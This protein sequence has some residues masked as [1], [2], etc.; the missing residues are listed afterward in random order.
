MS[1]TNSDI[2]ADQVRNVNAPEEIKEAFS[3]W[4]STVQ[5]RLKDPKSSLFNLLSSIP[6]QDSVGYLP[7]LAL[8]Y[9]ISQ[10]DQSLPAFD[11]IRC[12]NKLWIALP[13]SAKTGLDKE[14]DLVVRKTY[15]QVKSSV[16]SLTSLLL[17]NSD[18]PALVD[19]TTKVHL[20]HR[21]LSLFIHNFDLPISHS[22]GESKPI[23]VIALPNGPLLGIACLAVSSYYTAVPLNTSGG[24]RQFRSE[25]EL[26]SPDAILV[27][28]SDFSKLGLNEPWVIE[29]GIQVVLAQP[30]ADMTFTTQP[31]S[32]PTPGS[33]YKVTANSGDDIS[34]LL[35]TSGTS[36]TKKKVPV[37]CI[38]L[39]TGITCVID[40]WGLTVQDSCLNMMPLN[41]VGG[42]VRNLFAPVLS[43]GSTILCP[44]FDPNLFWDILQDGRGS[45]YYASPSMHMSILAEGSLRPDILSRCHLRLV[46]NAAGGLLP[47]LAIRLRDAFKCTVLPSYGMTEC[48]PISTPPLGYTLD[49][50]GTS[51]IGCGPEISIL[52]ETDNKLSAGQVGRINVRGG[53]LFNGYLKDGQTDKTAFNKDGWFDTGDLGSLDQDGFLYLTGRGKEVINRGGE[54]I[55][56]FEVEEAI[57]IASQNPNSFL[58]R[59]VDQVMAFSAPH[60]LLQEV[61]GVALVL[62]PGKPRPDIRDIHG[63]LKTS[64]HVAKLPIVVVYINA[65]PT[66]N[67]KI[68]RIKFGER[69]ELEPVTAEM[70]LAEKHYEAICP[71]VNSNLNTKVAK[72]VCSTD[73]GMI[74]KEVEIYLPHNLEAHVGISHHD[75]TPEL[76]LAPK[77]H[78]DDSPDF[79]AI[80]ETLRARLKEYLDGIQY[81]SKITYLESPFPRFESGLIDD[82]GLHSLLEKSMASKSTA[83]HSDT[84]SQVRQAFS[85]VLDFNINEINSDSDFFELGGDS[86]SAGRLLSIIRRDLQVRIPVDQL[87]VGSRVCD[88]CALVSNILKNSSSSSTLDQDLKQSQGST[89]TYSS[90]NPF[91][92]IVNVLP[93]ILFYPMKMGFQWTILMYSLS[94]ISEK[95]NESNV[96]ARFLALVA[97]MFISRALTQIVAPFCGIA[98]KW[99]VIKRFE[100]GT[101]PMWGVYHTRWWIVQKVLIICG[102]VSFYQHNTART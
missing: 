89:R 25:V 81:P 87:F 75:G 64:L 26:A 92:L 53:P 71:P 31:L 7:L 99:I 46:C 97:S 90:T 45:W 85:E 86:L 21:Q 63:A 61:V 44:A 56:P 13:E 84:E 29:S 79:K 93:I 76:F 54:L 51:G 57:T 66:S 69:L 19:P 67:N 35:F 20:T 70:T 41:H 58:F 73:V 62:P 24:A 33:N 22:T 43:G 18:L 3:S 65:L 5:T 48:M 100:E 96:A 78:S 94:S 102:K 77:E 95:W 82:I 32:H 50:T 55:S 49:R 72:K 28:E 47:A 16:G 101:Y 98:F 40:S 39:L 91:V 59:R 6:A 60:Q 8:K 34:L 80:I 88:L 12:Y 2:L 52:D 30:D 23:I 4:V 1:P 74:S 14:A 10:A 42:L 15:S 83:S 68:V 9:L 17:L 11:I 27:L 36:G 37:T 38:G